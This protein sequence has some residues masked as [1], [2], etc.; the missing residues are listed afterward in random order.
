MG[1]LKPGRDFAYPDYGLNWPRDPPFDL[2]RLVLDLE[3]DLE[4]RAVRGK[5]ANHL[6]LRRRASSVCL[7]A[8]DMKI[9]GVYVDGAEAEH[10]YDGRTLEVYFGKELEGGSA[11]TVKVDYS[12]VEPRRGVWFVPVDGGGPAHE[13][14]TQGEPE[15][16]RYWIPTYDYPDRKTLV[17]MTL[18]VPKGYYA[19]A[20]GM[21]V[22]RMEE[23]DRVAWVYRLDRPIPVYLIAFAVG[24]Y[25]VVEER[26]GDVLL[27][28]VVPEDRRED[29]WR[30]F[31]KTKDML[32]FFERYTGVRYPYPKY[33][34]VC[35]GEFSVGGMENASV[36]LLT[37]YTL[38]D[39]HAHMD[40]RSEPLVS[41]EL[42]H[43]WFGDLVTCKDWG[44]IWLNESFATLMQALWRREDEGV[45]EFVYDMVGK[46]DSYLKEYGSK[47]AR[48]VS[49]RVYKS[50]WELFDAHSYPKGALILWTLANIIGEEDFR[51]GIRLYLED[52]AD[53]VADTE[54]LKAALERASGTD[55]DWFFDQYVYS[56]GHPVLKVGYKWVNEDRMLELRVEQ[57]QK[58][59]S[60][61]AYRLKLDVLFRGDGYEVSKKFDI[62]EKL[63]VFHVPLDSRPRIVCIDPEFRT[64]MELK[65]DVGVEELL[66]VARECRHVYPRVVALRELARR[67]TPRMIPELS[68]VMVDEGEFWGVRV[69]AANAI[70]KIGGAAAMNALLSSLERVKHPKVRRAIVS[71]LGN[72]KDERVFAKLREILDD[73]RE[74]YY[75]R[76]SAAVSVGKIGGRGSFEALKKALGYPS[77]NNVIAA[78][79]LEGLSHLGTDEALGVVLDYTSPDR[80]LELRTTATGLLTRFRL[81]GVILDRLQEM[82]RSAHPRIRRAVVRAAEYSLDARVIP[83]LTSLQEDPWI[84]RAARDAARKIQRHVERGEEYRKLREEIDRIREE[85]RKLYERLERIEHKGA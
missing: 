33:A 17:E 8:Y 60:I 40:F 59:D 10:S 50:P 46:L 43:Q 3:I 77:H 30:S 62:R 85:E 28:Y 41:H 69:E 83:L 82:A 51:R 57:V 34:Q 9:R 56:S 70:A 72:F 47:Y 42:A 13:A 32:K 5:A 18:R 58:E 84:Y 23:G 79:A 24:K 20:N 67:G 39:E 35:V 11:V 16:N 22:D 45:D 55:L 19:V 78:G 73:G 48:P 81:T 31:S 76:S 25:H 12:V 1:G 71:N 66:R 80:P 27:Q 52:R 14:W 53:G 75:V 44:D 74:S 65:M 26:Y 7:D 38:H 6:M 68:D 4:D 64:F 37:A 61:D 36:T 49:T 21:L 54:H 2:A 63:H 29:L 15:D